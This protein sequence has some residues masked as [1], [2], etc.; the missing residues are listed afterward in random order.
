MVFRLE[1]LAMLHQRQS[2]SVEEELEFAE[3]RGSKREVV[4]ETQR[5]PPASFVEVLIRQIICGVPIVLS[6]ALAKHRH[7]R[8]SFRTGSVMDQGIIPHHLLVEEV[9]GLHL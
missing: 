9:V 7:N 4:D 1:G 6:H 3:R 5:R 2:L 8:T